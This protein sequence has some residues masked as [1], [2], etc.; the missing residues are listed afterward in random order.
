MENLRKPSLRT[1]CK[2]RRFPGVEREENDNMESGFAF[3]YSSSNSRWHIPRC[4]E[5]LGFP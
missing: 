2:T 1:H 4:H 5:P 3:T